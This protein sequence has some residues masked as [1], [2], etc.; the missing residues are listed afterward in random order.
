MLG[1]FASTGYVLVSGILFAVAWAVSANLPPGNGPAAYG[2]ATLLYLALS[3]AVVWAPL[4]IGAH[5]HQRLP[6]GA[7]EDEAA[8]PGGTKKKLRPRRSLAGSPAQ[9]GVASF[10]N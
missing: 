9:I 3:V 6:M 5:P 2:I 8:A 1:F 7:L 10:T 4:K